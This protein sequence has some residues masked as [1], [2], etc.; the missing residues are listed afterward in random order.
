M[1]RQSVHA[2]ANP[3]LPQRLTRLVRFGPN[4][5]M[6]VS[7]RGVQGIERARKRVLPDLVM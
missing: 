2:L 3:A 1:A 4:E 7:E 6:Q 5:V